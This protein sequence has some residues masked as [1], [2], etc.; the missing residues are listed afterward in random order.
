MAHPRNGEPVMFIAPE[1]TESAT[2]WSFLGRFLTSS[3]PLSALSTHIQINTLNEVFKSDESRKQVQGRE[4][5]KEG[6][7]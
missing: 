4:N 6:E 5:G 1:C 2:S 3:Y 7:D